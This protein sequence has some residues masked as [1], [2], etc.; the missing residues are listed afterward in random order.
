[1]T[2]LTTIEQMKTA[3]ERAK[4]ADLLVRVVAWRIY[5]VTNRENG[6]TYTVTFAVN[7]G[8]RFADCTCKGGQHD[9]ICKHMMAAAAR[10]IVI[11]E[12]RAEATRPAAVVPIVPPAS[13]MAHLLTPPPAHE[14]AIL[15]KPQ[16]KIEKVRGVAI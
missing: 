9:L 11:A 12:E 8:E 5:E 3:I 1:M 6:K 15:Q 16:S 13:L 7:R 4:A 14:T 10:H 2:K